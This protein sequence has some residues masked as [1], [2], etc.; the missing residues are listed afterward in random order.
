MSDLRD[1]YQELIVD[2][3]KNPRNFREIPDANRCADGFNPL[4]GDKLRLYLK[5]DDEG[6]IRDAAFKGSGCAIS[7]A[8]A[9]IMTAMVKNQ[10]VDRARDLFETFHHLV[11][12]PKEELDPADAG[13]GFGED[14][15][16][17]RRQ[18]VP[19]AREV[20]H[21]RLAHAEERLWKNKEEA[22]Q[23]E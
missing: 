5:V 9:S 21:A 20:R 3:S 1:L 2:H 19:G 6:I 18:R 4:C 12:R 15:C 13:L 16:L 8:S 17:R 14:G 23:T 22:A 10:S 11:T 7:T